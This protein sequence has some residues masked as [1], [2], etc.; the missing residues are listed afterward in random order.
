[1][2]SFKRVRENVIN[3]QSMDLESLKVE[4]QGHLS[5]IA[6]RKPK[7]IIL[8]SHKIPMGVSG[9]VKAGEEISAIMPF[10][11]A[12]TLQDFMSYVDAGVKE[13][14]VQITAVSKIGSQRVETRLMD[15]FRVYPTLKADV[16]AT[17]YVKIKILNKS[18][19][20]TD[21]I[22]G[23]TFK[24]VLQNEIKESR[25]VGDLEGGINA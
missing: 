16:S 3:L 23:F 6:T 11:L 25:L 9:V 12:G 22:V 7:D 18:K 4:L 14:F 15:S 20:D 1:M 5:Y 21:C 8:E 17:S 19:V 24:E 10:P 2:D 13:V